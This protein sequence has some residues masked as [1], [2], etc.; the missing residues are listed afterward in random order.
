MK[1]QRKDI[2]QTITDRIVADLEQGVRPW[3]KPWSAENTAGRITR[4]LRH[5][6]EA[7]RGINILMLWGTA[8]TSGFTSPYWLTF[9]QAR[10]LGAHVR[11]GEK[12]TPVVYAN[13][14][15]KV[16]EDEDGQ[17]VERDIPF[18]KGYTVFNA[19]QI[20]DLP[21]PYT[22]QPEP[23]A[24]GP[25]R[26]ARAED[27]IA[28]TGADIRIGGAEAYYTVHGDMI[29]VPPIEAFRDAERYYATLAHELTHWTR[30]PDRLDR[31]FGR[32]RFGDEGYAREELVA[33]LGSAFLAADLDIEP[34]PR[35]DHASYLAYWLQV[36][37]NDNRAI[38]AAAAHAQRAA[39]Y[40]H[41][42][43]TNAEA[44]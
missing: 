38:F 39:N 8:S 3:L 31:D 44:A 10:K 12:G 41:A 37:R 20:E 29:R 30:H 11:K 33:E 32:K 24:P 7:Y 5:N 42:L 22:A 17:E 16:E 36:L 6:G 14:F 34:E 19:D 27:F 26:I 18:L 23:P 28:K 4:P 21:A 40:L 1:R 25:E 2:Y 9:R 35:E 13:T 43:Q 15:R